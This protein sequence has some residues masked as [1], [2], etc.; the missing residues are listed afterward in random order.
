MSL[1]GGLA[2]LCVDT[3]LFLFMLINYE[4]GHP[5][6]CEW[7][8]VDHWKN[9]DEDADASEGCEMHWHTT[10]RMTSDS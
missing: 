6:P 7:M 4:D 8:R 3:N 2:F 1:I 5:G 10:E 9:D